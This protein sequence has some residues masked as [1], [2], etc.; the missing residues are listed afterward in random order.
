MMQDIALYYARH[1]QELDAV[2]Y[3]AILEKLH[4]AGLVNGILWNMIRSG[5]F[6]VE[7][8]PGLLEEKSKQMG[9]ILSDLIQ[10]GYM[11]VKQKT[12]RLESGMEYNRQLLR[13]QQSALQYRLHML[14]WKIKSGAKYMIP[15]VMML[16]KLYPV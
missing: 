14:V 8:F 12:E 1:K 15:S 4:Y 16:Q 10:G 7:D 13:K 5:G 11:G 9:V 6:R 3:W 2:R